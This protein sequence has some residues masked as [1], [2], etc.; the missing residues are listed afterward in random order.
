MRG[1]PLALVAAAMGLGC[2]EATPTAPEPI[3][4]AAIA[5]DRDLVAFLPARTDAVLAVDMT[6]L[7]ASRFARPMLGA[8]S[9]PTE[10]DGKAPPPR[11][12]RGFDEI[13]DVERYLFAQVGTPGGERATLELVRGRFDRAR[14]AQAFRARFAGAAVSDMDRGEGLV[15]AEL[16]AAF[17]S[18]RVLAFGAPWA[19][20]AA[21]AVREGRQPSV[22]GA[23][24]LTAADPVWARDDTRDKAPVAVELT[25]QATSSSRAALAQLLETQLPIEHLA[26]RL[27]VGDAARALI[28]ATASSPDDAQDLAVRLRDTLLELR[29]RPSI[30]ALGLAPVLARADLAARG[31]RLALVLAITEQE[32]EL[33]ATRLA[34]LGALLARKR[35]E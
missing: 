31:P 10:V 28:V 3:A 33:V 9:D 11:Q 17:L 21:V 8:L 16:A 27:E 32:R 14:V 26:A 2:A 20:R 30:T 1:A 22:R 5:D 35:S 19:V 15:S 6:V 24:W 29:A 23:P 7:R 18:P 4:R 12:A 25:V 34:A 13:L